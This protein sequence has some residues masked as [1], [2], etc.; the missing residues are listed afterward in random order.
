MNHSRTRLF[1]FL[2]VVNEG[3]SHTEKIVSAVG[4]SLGIFLV[5]WTS[6]FVTGVEGS[7]YI[8]PSM[9]ASA[10]L[11][12][13]VPHGKLS[14]PW[15]LIGGHTISALVGVTC[16]LLIPDILLAA[17]LAVG[18]AIGFM[19]YARC[20]HPPG[21]ATA[22]AAV[23]GGEAIHQLGYMFILTPVLINTLVIFL[24]A[25]AFNIFFHWRHYPANFIPAFSQRKQQTSHKQAGAMDLSGITEDD[26]ANAMQEMD[27]IIDTT[28][29][30]LVKLYA[31]AS[32]HA[33]SQQLQP[34]Q[35][36]LGK[37]YSNGLFGKQ[38]SVRQ[39]VDKSSHANPD[40]DMVIYKIIA[41]NGRR[42]SG[43]CTRKEFAKWARYEVE[44]HESAWQR[45]QQG[46]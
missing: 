26:I 30:D 17:A 42:E 5:A 39:I 43:K 28:T 33:Q 25:I 10:V 45:S 18:I 16:Y 8:V 9:G 11:L 36:K 20:I 2:G 3:I 46:D 15:A 37:C 29:E 14:Q 21:G 23:I 27:I 31:L 12:F 38:W 44:R 24:T 6:W 4:G 35:I 19:H 40:R 7:I 32:K 1:E 34:H 41:G 13:A 22:L